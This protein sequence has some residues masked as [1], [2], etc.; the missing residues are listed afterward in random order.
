[1]IE[2]ILKPNKILEPQLKVDFDDPEIKDRFSTRVVIVVVLQT[3]HNNFFCV[4]LPNETILRKQ[5]WQ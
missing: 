4:V 5:N 3:T 1:M 2:N